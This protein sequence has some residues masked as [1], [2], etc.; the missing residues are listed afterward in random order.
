MCLHKSKTIR[1][2]RALT[3]I[4][5]IVLCFGAVF[6]SA[7]IDWEVSKGDPIILDKNFGFG[8]HCIGLAFV[9]IAAKTIISVSV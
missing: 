2:I 8:R 1:P 5:F 9:L 3:W 7:L 4:E 6:H